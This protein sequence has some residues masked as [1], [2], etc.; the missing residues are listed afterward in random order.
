MNFE[1]SDKINYIIEKS[2]VW[3]VTKVLQCEKISLA[4][5]ENV[6]I[7]KLV[8]ENAD[9]NSGIIK[10]KVYSFSAKAKD[11]LIINADDFENCFT[12]NTEINDAIMKFNDYNQEYKK[13]HKPAVV[14]IITIIVMILLA[15]ATTFFK[16][17]LVIIPTV[18]ALVALILFIKDYEKLY[19]AKSN[20][21]FNES[22]ITNILEENAGKVNKILKE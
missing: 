19:R 3:T 20:A 14:E 8:P 22:K 1:F 13:M 10:L 17:I 5:K 16:P 12:P 7:E 21:S 4:E 15:L 11:T 9:E 6:H 18:V 2:A